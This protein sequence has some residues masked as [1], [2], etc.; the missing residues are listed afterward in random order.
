MEV[1]S[2]RCFQSFP[3]ETVFALQIGV[4]EMAAHVL[5]AQVNQVGVQHICFAI[6]T[7]IAYTSGQKAFPD[8][9]ARHAHFAGEAQ[10]R[11]DRIQRC[12]RTILKAGQHIHQINM[13]PVKPRQVIVIAKAAIFIAHFP[14]TW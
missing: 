9:V 10:H 1:F 2:A 3:D 8:F 7:N 11:R 5:K 14:V 6:V 12:A 4:I 13:P